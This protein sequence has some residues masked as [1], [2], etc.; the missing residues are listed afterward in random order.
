MTIASLVFDKISVSMLTHPTDRVS[1]ISS[2]VSPK[3]LSSFPKFKSD[4]IP[5]TKISGWLFTATTAT[6][7]SLMGHGKET[8]TMSIN[9]R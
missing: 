8:E 5:R 9:Q 1:L 7:D 6:L 2:G 3:L 4:V